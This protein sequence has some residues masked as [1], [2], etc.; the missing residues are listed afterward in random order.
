MMENEVNNKDWH[1]IRNDNGEW[2]SDE[3][4]M[5]LTPL[6]AIVLEARAAQQGKPFSIQHGV[7][8]QLWCY[9]HELEAIDFS[10]YKPANRKLKIEKVHMKRR[11]DDDFNRLK[12]WLKQKTNVSDLPQ[13]YTYK[14]EEQKRNLVLALSKKGLKANMQENGSAF[15]SWAIALK[16]YLSDRIKT[17][18]IDWEQMPS[19]D[20][21]NLHFNRFVYRLS[22]FVQTFEWALSAKPIPQIPSML[23]CNFPNN[24]AAEAKEHDVGSEGWIECKYVEKYR[25]KYDVMNHQLPV[26]IFHD[27]VSRHTHYTTG[28]KSAIDI[29]AIKDNNLFIFELKK[30]DNNV[31]GVISELMFYTNIFQD[32][33]SHRILYQHDA[34]LQVAIKKNY[35]GFR[36][37]YG[38]YNSGNIKS[39][40]AIILA[41]TIHPLIKPELIDFINNSARLKYCRINYSTRKVEI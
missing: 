17:V 16:Y 26:G 18:T 21:N 28:Q 7:E 19:G 13:D 25:K 31:L 36:D 9:R 30:P 8:G 11:T 10:T 1:L 6:D 29:W 41:D 15:E 5:F 38:S 23:V 34:K 32:I 24:K 12:D 14:Y 4:A 27:K 22:K 39:I 2:I 40:N 37:L 3:Y 33:M 35:R 20:D